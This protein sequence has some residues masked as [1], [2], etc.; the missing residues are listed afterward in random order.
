VLREQLIGSPL[1]AIVMG[2][3]DRAILLGEAIRH[4]EGVGN[5]FNNQLA[6]RLLTHIVSPGATFIDIGAHI[7]SVISAARRSNAG[8]IIAFEAIP[9]K[10]ARLQ[11]KFQDVEIHSCALSD[12]TGQ[13]EFFINTKASGYSSLN[14]TGPDVLQIEVALEMLDNLV[15]ASD[16]DIIKIDV[17]GAELG[18]LR[19]GERLIE[20]CRPTIM[21][22]SGPEDVLGYTKIAMWDW[23][24]ARSYAIYAPDRLAHTGPPMSL[25][26]FLDSH[27]YPRRTTNYF[28]VH[29]TRI[30]DVRR[31]ARLLPR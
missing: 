21:F 14:R 8:K 22:E 5:T 12:R 16:V 25:E 7:G 30:E 3:R 20:R 9:D 6:C 31:K 10:A 27:C 18:V 26:V 19:G 29:I 2:I 11:R 23:L 13:A 28:A 15:K 1:E 17:E 24:H 4:L